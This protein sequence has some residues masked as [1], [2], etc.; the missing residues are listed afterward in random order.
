MRVFKQHKLVSACTCLQVLTTLFSLFLSISA[1]AQNKDITKD[2]SIYQLL[3]DIKSQP[4]TSD[5]LVILNDSAYQGDITLIRSNDIVS[6]DVIK[7]DDAKKIYGTKA[8]NG[9]FLMK[10]K[11]YVETGISDNSDIIASAQTK[12]DSLND[13]VLYIVNGVPVSENAIKNED[14]LIKYVLKGPSIAAMNFEN[15]ID[16]VI[17]IITKPYAITQYQKKFNAFSKKYKSYLDT[18]QDNDGDLLFVLDGVPVQGKRNDIIKTLYEIP[19]R[20]IKEIG[21]TEKQPENGSA[22]LVIINTK[23]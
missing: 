17:A 19:S 9:A 15:E 5:P 1:L 11:K 3:Q 7:G 22:T 13:R 12:N 2:T 20:T 6:I 23:Q 18:H 14:I 8:Q 10:T 4:G 16:S 21:F